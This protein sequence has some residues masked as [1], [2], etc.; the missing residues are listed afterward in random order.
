MGSEQKD[1][2]MQKEMEKKGYSSKEKKILSHPA[3]VARRSTRVLSTLAHPRAYL[4]LP[5]GSTGKKSH[6][7]FPPFLRP[8]RRLSPTE[9]QYPL[10]YPIA[11]AHVTT[12]L[13]QTA[14]DC[15]A[16]RY[17]SDRP[18]RVRAVFVA[19]RFTPD[20]VFFSRAPFSVFLPSAPFLSSSSPRWSI[21]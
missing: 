9:K 2:L 19:V 17:Q 8:P 18:H 20:R 7:T 21:V 14:E 16:G 10:S 6:G 1:I 12:E 3:P 11:T 5:E 4:N 13:D 15:A